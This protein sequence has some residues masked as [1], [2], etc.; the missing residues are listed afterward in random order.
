VPCPT[1]RA[2]GGFFRRTRVTSRAWGSPKIPC[3]WLRARNP[4]KENKAERVWTRFMRPPGQRRLGVC[5]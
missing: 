1:A 5:H 2:N 3:S 4:G